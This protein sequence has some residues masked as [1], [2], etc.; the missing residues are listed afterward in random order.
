MGY[1]QSSRHRRCNDDASNWH[2]QTTY[3][4]LQCLQVQRPQPWLRVFRFLHPIIQYALQ[5]IKCTT[6]GI[7]YVVLATT[8][9]VILPVIIAYSA[10]ALT[11][12]FIFYVVYC[13][14]NV[15]VYLK[16]ESFY[17]VYWKW[18]SILIDMFIYYRCM[19]IS[20]HMPRDLGTVFILYTVYWLLYLKQR[21]ICKVWAWASPLF[22]IGRLRLRYH[23]NRCIYTRV[24]HTCLDIIHRWY[25]HMK[26]MI[27]A[28]TYNRMKKALFLVMWVLTLAIHLA[29]FCSL[30]R[31]FSGVSLA[32]AA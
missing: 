31:L 8:A 19:L 30:S 18:M 32:L 20:K 10:L 13:L 11:I 12:A 9:S 23:C 28:I 15:I 22:V 14:H 29:A 3:H 21:A 16:Q 5:Y 24:Q 2:N 27:A 6:Y 25:I 7:T 26:N 1:K 17:K 4:N